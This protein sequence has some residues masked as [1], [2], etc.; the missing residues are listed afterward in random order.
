MFASIMKPFDIHD[1]PMS[2]TPHLLVSFHL[3]FQGMP[4]FYY[5][6]PSD[7]F[8]ITMKFDPLVDD[9]P[10]K[11]CQHFLALTNVAN[12]LKNRNLWSCVDIANFHHYHGYLRLPGGNFDTFWKLEAQPQV[13]AVSLLPAVWP[14]PVLRRLPPLERCSAWCSPASWTLR[15]EDP[16]SLSTQTR[17]P[18]LNPMCNTGSIDE[19]LI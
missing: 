9:L 7:N 2:S 19:G 3:M 14:P 11:H 17:N 12:P 16:S 5:Y 1:L 15:P 4:S 18:F 13:P 10:S 6:V 8:N